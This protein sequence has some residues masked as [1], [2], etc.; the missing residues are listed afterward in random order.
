[1]VFGKNSRARFPK[2]AR[3]GRNNRARFPNRCRFSVNFTV[4]TV[5]PVFGKNGNRDTVS[6]IG[7][8]FVKIIG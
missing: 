7:A 2:G 5:R 1:M 3:L 8:S 6:P 4:D